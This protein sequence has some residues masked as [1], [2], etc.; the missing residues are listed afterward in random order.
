MIKLLKK[1]IPKKILDFRHLFYAWYGAVK[2]NHPS[3]EMLV[4]GVT[5]TTGKSSVIHFLR[6]MLEDQGY[7]VGSL[8]T[9]DFY[10]AG[11]EKLNDQKMT[12]L[13]KMKIQEYLRQMAD[14]GCDIAIV[15]TTSEGYLQYRHKFINY[16]MMILTGLYPEHIESH[17]GFENYKAA[18]L[19]I[20][21][22][23]SCQK[24]KVKSQKSI[25]KTAIV[26]G[27]CKY[28]EEFLQFNFGKKIIFDRDDEKKYL[29]K[30]DLLSITYHLS[31]Y[32]TKASAD[33]LNFAI[34][35]RGFQ[36]KLYGEYNVMN[37]LAGIS[38]LRVLDISWSKI[39]EAV[40][41][42]KSPPG[43][44][45]F[46]NEAEEKGFKVI[47]DYA[48]EPVALEALYRVVE[49]IKPKRVI[50]V[51]GSTGGGR[52]KGRRKPIG[53]LVGEKADIF[54]V[55]DEDPYD[56]DPMEIIKQVS[57][58]AQEVGKKLDKD[59]FEVLDRKLAIKLA[60]K[61]ANSGDLILVTGKGSEQA[62]CI[63]GGVMIP[64]DDRLIVK[65]LL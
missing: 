36:P 20:F 57:V 61:M 25:K 27:N 28:A 52:D 1:I 31:S 41:D 45:E 23:V 30:K 3:E 29:T 60:I 33:G 6:Q 8:S 55:T 38:V 46:I 64:W 42:L 35:Q 21:G 44:L 50:H 51:C 32:N 62:M 4:V 2:Y 11:K 47:V 49:I 14:A 19:G 5:G 34:G 40:N 54:I 39:E 16:D 48:F 58:G 43:R 24:L 53:K 17:G 37:I 65:E 22:Y 56:E 9:V 10:I 26:N 63:K 7:K 12:M 18:K 59:L 13:G 15:E